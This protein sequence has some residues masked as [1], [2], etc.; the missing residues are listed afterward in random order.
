MRCSQAVKQ[1]S[2]Y[3]DGE[4]GGAARERL[5]THLASCGTC[6]AALL[7]LERVHGLFAQA[8]RYAPPPWLA[9]RVAAAVRE[10]GALRRPLF[11]IALRLT[12]QAVALA[13]VIAIGSLSGKLLAAGA[14][15]GRPGGP[16]SLFS[17]DLFA[18]VPPDSPGGVYLAMTEAGRE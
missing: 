10:R 5:S 2:A 1:L 12:A 13:A 8:E 18:A 16:A 17:L 9:Q 14:A 4:L 7:Q 11:P 3:L 6:R 15:A